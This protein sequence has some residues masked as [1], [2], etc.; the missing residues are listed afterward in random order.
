MKRAKILQIGNYPPPMCGWAMQLTLVTAELRRRGST[1]EVLKINEGRRAKSPE[2]VDVQNGFDFLW[3]IWRYALQGYRLNVHV[4]GCSK[5][6]YFLALAAALTG[7]VTANPTRVTFHGG[8]SQYYFPQPRGIWR[9]AFWL[10]FHA[11]GAIACDSPEIARE[12]AMYDVSPAKIASIATFSPQYVDYSPA[13]LPEDVEVFLARWPRIIFCYV[14]F[15]P[16]YQLE[17]L[18]EAMRRYRS[19]HSEA[20]FIWLGF[21]AQELTQMQQWLAAWQPGER[22]G[23]LLLGSLP[24]DEFLTLLSRSTLCLRTPACDGVAASVLEALALGVPVIASENGSRPAGV[25]T[26]EDGNVDDLVAKLNEVPAR[27]E[28]VRTSLGASAAE[29]NV[30][31]MADWLMNGLENRS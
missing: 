7:R 17:T 4:N 24:H 26:Y 16:E 23:L 13:R 29:N 9:W 31:K 6:G 3:K 12:I 10:L 19:Q 25:V 11:A 22:D 27:V 8:L 18:R 20:G 15:R 5:K 28:G 14:S 1:C 30:A 2:Y 21:P